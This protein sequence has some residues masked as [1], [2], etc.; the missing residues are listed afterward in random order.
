M[1]CLTHPHIVR[2]LEA[3]EDNQRMYIVMEFCESGTLE[4]IILKNMKREGYGNLNINNSMMA[5]CSG[6]SEEDCSI[7]IGRVLMGI[8]YIHD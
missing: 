4:E 7:I 2:Y 1:Q 5:R 6:L 3:Y 8:A